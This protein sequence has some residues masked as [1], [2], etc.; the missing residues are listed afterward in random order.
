MEA[1]S[2]FRH[3]AADMVLIDMAMA[4][5]LDT[6]RG[7]LGLAASTKVLALSVPE[8]DQEVIA[9][10]EAGAIAYVPRTGSIRDLIEA[11]RGASRG[12]ARSSPRV[13][14]SLLQRLAMLAAGSRTGQPVAAL[15]VRELQVMR[16]IGEGYSNK[17]IALELRISLP[18]V[19]NHVHHVL[20][21][22]RVRRRVEAATLWR[23]RQAIGAGTESPVES[24]R[25]ALPR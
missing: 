14:A 2:H 17:D 21:K 4:E 11:I 18:T 19:K 24:T 12:E 5:S 6:I 9:C 1:L 10:A 16:L 7:I 25:E 22:L 23:T 15:T 8:V 20:E 13:V 3:S